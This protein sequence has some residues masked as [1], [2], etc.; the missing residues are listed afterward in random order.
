MKNSIFLLLLGISLGSCHMNKHWVKPD[1]AKA[2]INGSPKKVIVSE[3]YELQQQTSS[4][5][6]YDIVT[7]RE[8][9]YARDMSYAVADGLNQKGI[10]TI[11]KV[12]AKPRDLA[13][14]EYLLRGA[15]I[16]PA[17]HKS[18][19]MAAAW[20]IWGGSLTVFGF[21]LPYPGFRLKN[22]CGYKFRV[23]LIDSRGEIVFSKLDDFNYHEE[24]LYLLG[25]P[26]CQEELPE[27]RNILFDYIAKLV[28][29]ND[30]AISNR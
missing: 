24:S 12:G 7:I 17:M 2:R 22:Y 26:N 9:V 29:D 23:D 19:N 14:G 20:A 28:E 1:Y 11:A 15:L 6:N 5:Y 25:K 8:S 16:S 21:Y 4:T 10:N 13:P 18:K 30:R 3:F 27:A